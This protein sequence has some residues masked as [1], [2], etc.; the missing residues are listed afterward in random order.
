MTGQAGGAQG[1]ITSALDLFDLS[2]MHLSITHRPRRQAFKRL[3]PSARIAASKRW[4]QAMIYSPTCVPD[5]EKSP[6]TAFLGSESLRPDKDLSGLIGFGRFFRHSHWRA[7]DM[8]SMR[9]IR[10]SSEKPHQHSCP[11]EEDSNEKNRRLLVY[12]SVVT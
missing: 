7:M 6:Y 8:V 5:Q 2:P 3:P 9:C 4:V 11:G 12:S 1:S 10:L